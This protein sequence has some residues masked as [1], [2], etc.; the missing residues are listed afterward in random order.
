M[1]GRDESRTL[2]RMALENRADREARKRLC[3]IGWTKEARDASIRV[4]QLKARQNAEAGV[5]VFARSMQVPA[6][7]GTGGGQMG[8][9]GFEDYEKSKSRLTKTQIFHKD[10]KD[11]IIGKNGKLERVYPVLPA[12]G[13]TRS[14]GG[15]SGGPSGQRAQPGDEVMMDGKRYVMG[16]DGV[17]RDPETNQ[18]YRKEEPAT[19]A[20]KPPP[21]VPEPDYGPGAGTGSAVPSTTAPRRLDPGAPSMVRKGVGPRADLYNPDQFK[22]RSP[23]NYDPKGNAPPG[24]VFKKGRPWTPPAVGDAPALRMPGGAAGRRP[25]R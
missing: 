15:N 4:R 16:Q 17:L 25:F 6:G 13:G 3:N 18:P 10:G 21:D 2:R 5:G 24:Y 7:R 9:T 23:G 12:G 8:T 14:N 1:A 11:F 19:V 22:T 20:V